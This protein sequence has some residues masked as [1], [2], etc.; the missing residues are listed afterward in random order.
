MASPTAAEVRTQINNV[1]ALLDKLYNAYEVDGTNAIG[2]IDTLQQSLEGD[3]TAGVAG[4][5][6][7]LRS[8]LSAAITPATVRAMLDPLFL[9]YGKVLGFPEQDVPSILDRLYEYMVNNSEDVNGRGI[10]RGAPAA[11]GSNVGNGTWYV[12][13]T[14]KYGFPIESDIDKTEAMEAKCIS[15]QTT[16]VR[17]EEV[18]RLRSGDAPYDA[19]ERGGQGLVAEISTTSARNSLL[20]NPSFSQG[21]SG[22]TISNWTV[23]AGAVGNT[24]KDTTNFYRGFQGDTTPAALQ[25]GTANL[26]LQQ[27]LSTI[28]RRFDPTV[29][30]HF[31]IAWNRQVGSGAGT[32]L[33]RL[34]ATNNSIAVAAQ[35]GWQIL[36]VTATPGQGNWHNSFYED[37][38]DI[39][40][41]WTHTS[42]TVLIDDC[43][44]VP[45][46]QFGSA[47]HMI[48]GGATP[49]S[50][51]DV[52]TWTDTIA[53]D[54]K[55][56]FWIQYAYDGK[57]LPSQS[58]GSE[59]WTDP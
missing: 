10:S 48:R 19:M 44:L 42:G 7:G 50:Y 38:L 26:T 54:S 2:L 49:F 35:T 43:L 23:A 21:T 31:S 57:Y 5:I 37:D 18:F 40:I 4:G 16:G 56:Q 47:Y 27:K 32:L 36:S 39:S 9:T 17:H 22:S 1:V 12:N 45:M 8:G 24:A 46:V 29:P 58:D 20:L 34:G 13:G 25:I 14:D 11:G 41:E 6:E 33:I 30:Y 53:T 3:W 15:D 59:T 51:D 28:N 52:F 55:V